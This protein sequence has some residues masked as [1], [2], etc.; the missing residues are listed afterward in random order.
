MMADD[1][2][3][4]D[5]DDF[6]E[7]EC[8]N[9]GGDGVVFDCIDGFCEDFDIGCDLCTRRCDVCQPRRPTLDR[10]SER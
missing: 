3:M 10:G 7:S 1:Q 8:F 5:D 6:V 9:C 2:T 4:P